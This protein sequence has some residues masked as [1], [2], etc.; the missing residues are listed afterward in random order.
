MCRIQGDQNITI[1]FMKSSST[2]D[3]HQHNYQEDLE[4]LST[5]VIRMTKITH[6]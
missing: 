4:I 2:R 3:H 6:S 1:T 5:S